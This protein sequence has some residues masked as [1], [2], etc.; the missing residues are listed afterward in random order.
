[1]TRGGREKD[2]DEPE[3]KCLATGEVSP[4]SGLVRFV[5]GPDDG[6]VPDIAAK[7]PGRGMYVS[8]DRAAIAMAAKKNLFSRA[9]RQPVKAPEGLADLVEVLLARRVVELL[10][11]ARKANSAVTGYEKVKDWLEKGRAAVL[12]QAEDG[13]ERG[14]TKLRPPSGENSL[15]SCLNAGEIGLAFGRERAKDTKDA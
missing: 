3:R 9:A 13:S 11:M 5:V 15:I 12:I 6:V 14:K 4:K 1:M 10:S 8:A 7:L 2:Q